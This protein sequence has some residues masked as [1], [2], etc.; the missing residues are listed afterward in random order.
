MLG[1]LRAR[2]RSL[3]TLRRRNWLATLLPEEGPLDLRILGRTLLHA[4]LVG[5]A[6]GLVG[7]LFFYCL[8]LVQ[9]VLLEW[10]CGYVPLR[11]HGE[12]VM[13]AQSPHRFRPYLLAILPGVGGLLCGLVTSRFA[14]EAS[15]GGGNAMIHAYHQQGG[16]LRRRVIW[17]KLIASTLTLGTGGAGGRE[18]PTMQIGAA[19][20]ATV[21]RILNLDAR[22]RRILFIAGVAAGISAVFR[23]PL[24]AALLAVEVLYRDDFEADALIPAILASVIGYS[25]VTA[26]YGESRLFTHAPAYPFFPAHLPLYILLALAVSLCAIAFVS[27]LRLVQ[28]TA[29]RLPGPV[30]LRPAIGG[31]LL[32]VL[33]TP[34]VI[35]FGH[36]LH[37]PG[38][39]LGLF[40]GG[41]GAAQL[42]ITGASWLP[43]GWLAVGLLLL[44]GVVKLFAASLTIGS[45]GSAG[46]FAP[47][48]ALGA[49]LGGAFGRALA[50]LL[51]D[52]RIDPGAFALVGMGTFYGGIAH[53][54]LSALVLTCEL[55]GSYDLLVPLMLAGG[56]AFMTLRR[57]SLYPAQVGFLRDSPVHRSE[58]LDLLSRVSVQQV[59]SV[60]TTRARFEPQIRADEILRR[61]GDSEACEIF[62]VQ[63]RVG[64]LVGII[65]AEALLVLAGQ[66]ESAL[67][68]I[69]AD[70]MEPPASLRTTDTLREAS[71]LMLQR[72][73]P[74]LPV[75]DA[76]GRILG[77]LD[78][79]AIARTYMEASGQ[80]PSGPN[81][82]SSGH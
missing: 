49:L 78:E 71:R 63:D 10:L 8:E 37:Q 13:D 14:P 17:T 35:W 56:V 29:A 12:H 47:S 65:R 48:L 68:T 2:I 69:A 57:W 11:A 73:L 41:Y 55:A 20:G 32:G 64:V 42:A 45:G 44:M 27:M 15:G 21:A 26:I 76:A 30:W 38:Q 33:C 23:T 80:D 31:L 24:G 40:G 36:S 58:H 6:A 51:H 22:E 16:H 53:A 54:P 77:Y 1:Q 18:G 79:T 39:G 7:A 60:D 25:V 19:I 81:S 4:A 61:I 74:E 75:V 3:L 5:A 66:P 70:I 9:R 72:K 34:I 43:G 59:L 28:R 50:L 67:Y 52:P 46:D 62:P 82:Q